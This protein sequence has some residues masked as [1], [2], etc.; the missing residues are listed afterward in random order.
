[1]ILTAACPQTQMPHTYNHLEL[2]G[3]ESWNRLGTGEGWSR[4]ES[5]DQKG[6]N[7][8]PHTLLSNLWINFF[9]LSLQVVPIYKLVK[10]V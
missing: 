2:V 10:P 9:S 3:R 6:S 7:H 5:Q 4:P 8:L 1:M